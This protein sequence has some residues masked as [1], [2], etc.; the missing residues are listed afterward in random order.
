VSHRLSPEA[1]AELDDIWLYIATGSGS[2]E[3]ADRFVDS[4]VDRFYLLARNPYIGRRRDKDLRPGLRSFPVDEYV[5]VY[6]IDGEDVL[7]LHVVRG[8]RDLPTLVGRN[9]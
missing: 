8:S 9:L 4:L 7:I 2:P 3:I 1:E 6:R 5:I